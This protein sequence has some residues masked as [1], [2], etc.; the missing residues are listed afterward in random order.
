MD[1]I[2]SAASVIAAG[3]AVGLGLTSDAFNSGT[4]CGA[5]TDTR[6]DGAEADSEAS[7]DNRRG[8]GDEIHVGTKDGGR[9]ESADWDRDVIPAPGTSQKT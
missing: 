8:G 2:T 6:A 9:W 1:S 5:L 7:S 3:L 4:G